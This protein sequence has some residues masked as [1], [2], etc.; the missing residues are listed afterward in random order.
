MQPHEK[1]CGFF[2]VKMTKKWY[3]GLSNTEDFGK[4]LS[5]S[6]FRD[7]KLYQGL[8]MRRKKVTS[9]KSIS[10][11]ISISFNRILIWVVFAITFISVLVL[12]TGQYSACSRDFDT[13]VGLASDRVYWALRSYKNI[14]GNMGAIPLLSDPNVSTEEKEKL[15]AN[16]CERYGLVRSKV[17][18]TDG[19]SDMDSEPIYRG[20][21]E[22][23][24]QA[25][26]G[27][28]YIQEPVTSRTDGQIAIIGAAPLWKAG[29]IGGEIAGVVF[30]S[31]NPILLHDIIEGVGISENTFVYI[32]DSYGSTVS[33]NDMNLV[34]QKNN[35]IK[36]SKTDKAY[37]S[38]ARVDERMIKGETGSESIYMDGGFYYLSY[39]PIRET[40]GW[41]ICIG[42]A[43]KDYIDTPILLMILM[44]EC[45]LISIFVVKLRAKKIADEVAE[46]VK[47]MTESIKKAAESGKELAD[48]EAGSEVDNP[49]EMRIISEAMDSILDRLDLAT[50]DSREFLDSA[51]I[52]DLVSMDMLRYIHGYYKEAFG[53]NVIVA[54]SKGT[55]LVGKT[56]H[57]LVDANALREDESACFIM[58]N[59]RVIGS[60]IFKIPEEC[61]LNKESAQQHAIYVSKILEIVAIGNFRR[62][63]QNRKNL[64]AAKK[65]LERISEYH[66]KISEEARK[67]AT[68]CEKA[69][70][71]DDTEELREL[72]ARF[73]A[74]CYDLISETDDLTNY[75][76]RNDIT[77]Q[78]RERI[79]QTEN[80]ISELKNDLE[81]KHPSLA[82][83]TDVR[84]VSGMPD[85]LF[86]DPHRVRR[87]C[88]N[89]LVA[90][91]DE[92]SDKEASIFFESRKSSYAASLMIGIHGN[93]RLEGKETDRL[94]QLLEA[95]NDSAVVDG[96][97][98]SDLKLLS[99]KRV[100]R[101]MNG[102]ITVN[103]GGEGETWCMVEIPQLEVNSYDQ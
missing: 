21:R 33:A 63:L 68:E 4:K 97:N 27:K 42:S 39:T 20:D 93:R 52:T 96:I 18:N 98:A 78:I 65:E 22:Y 61:I 2:L 34:Y 25:M 43:Y 99:I 7:H 54:D 53:V 62:S 81:R 50:A 91:S 75:N 90:I 41:S 87:L 57:G 9:E 5:I 14:V 67:L 49:I 44:A 56:N 46:P 36:N 95:D 84:M 76:D 59:D 26:E 1:T 19:F 77:L 71:N 100:V 82:G 13:A 40:P 32:I 79:Y 31:I 101:R 58:L 37:T 35:N 102:T 64:K 92:N 89:L 69:R 74:F 15:L 73:S 80:L 10:E 8:I 30:I 60:T 47:R 24:K 12:A 29:V 85:R 86:G 6:R 51:V 88:E 72:T 28:C 48:Y 3:Y 11:I 94:K 38:I 55:V 16:I 23:F 103:K 70:K 83:K 45:L 66:G 17:I